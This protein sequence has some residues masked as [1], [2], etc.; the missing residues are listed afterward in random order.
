MGIVC[1]P[2]VVNLGFYCYERD[3]MISPSNNNQ[4]DVIEAFKLYVKIS[5]VDDLLDIDNPPLNKW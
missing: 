3:I 2:L 5:L 1:A 4:V